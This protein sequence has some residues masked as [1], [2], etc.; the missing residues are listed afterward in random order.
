MS[1]P[2][3]SKSEAPATRDWTHGLQ[4]MGIFLCFGAVMS[5]FAGTTLLWHGTILDQAWRLNPNAYRQLALMGPV[6]GVLFLALAATMVLAAIGWFRRRLWG[7]RLAVAIVATQVL[8]DLANFIRGDFLRGGTGFA[9]AG[10]LL[11]YLWRPRVRSVF[12]NP[13]RPD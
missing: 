1:G 4:A 8:G 7:W 13:R 2:A 10:A 5:C 6:A 3:N 11:V 9:I 12:G